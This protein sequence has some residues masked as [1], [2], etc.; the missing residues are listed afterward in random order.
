ME[1]IALIDGDI[2]VYEVASAVETATNWGDG[3]WTLHADENIA[4]PRL[5]DRIREL[6]DKVFAERIVVCLSDSTNWRKNVLPTYKGNRADV[7]KPMLIPALQQYLRDNFEVMER[8]TLEADDVLGILATWK[9]LKGN[10][11]IITKDKDLKT[12]PCNFFNSNKAHLGVIEITEEEADRWHLMQALAGDV[13]DGYGGCPSVGLGTA[14][15]ILNDLYGWEQYD[16]EFKAGP[17]KGTTEKR[18]RKITCSTPWEALVSNYNKAGLGP[19]EA[20][21]QARVARICRASDYDFKNKKVILWT[22]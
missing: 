10:K 22:P 2:Y 19:E 12:I 18:W 8:P 1:T 6:A 15:E 5:D 20:L 16:H 17:R 4:I 13:T 9:G 14:E 21:V 7:R 3:L 11:I